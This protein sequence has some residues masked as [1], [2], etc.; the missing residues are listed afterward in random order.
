MWT[1]KFCCTVAIAASTPPVWYAVSI[2]PTPCCPEI[3]TQ[4]SRGIDSMVTCLLDGSTRTRIIDCVLY[5]SAA[6]LESSSEPSRST[7][8]GVVGPATGSRMAPP[9]LTTGVAEDCSTGR[10]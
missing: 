9:E 6:N 2:L 1:W 3:G 10:K 8:N 5:W 4:R 7:V